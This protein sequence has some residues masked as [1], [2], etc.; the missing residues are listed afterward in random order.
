MLLG[1]NRTVVAFKLC[2]LHLQ[3]S[4]CK[5]NSYMTVPEKP[6]L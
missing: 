4:K 1:N 6:I 5:Y 2:T 3:D